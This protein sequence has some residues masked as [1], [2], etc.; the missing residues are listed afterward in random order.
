MRTF[1]TWVDYY[2]ENTRRT[3][4]TPTMDVSAL[5]AKIAMGHALPFLSVFIPDGLGVSE[6]TFICQDKEDDNDFEVIFEEDDE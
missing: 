1:E 5:T 4:S 6:I 3:L 2:D